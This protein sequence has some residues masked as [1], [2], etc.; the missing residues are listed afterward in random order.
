M[1]VEFKSRRCGK[2][3]LQ[4]QR[5]EEARQARAAGFPVPPRISPE[6][7]VFIGIDMGGKDE[8][9]YVRFPLRHPATGIGE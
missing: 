2:T 3:E 8:T 9:V 7:A 6:N 5:V 4:R 1:K